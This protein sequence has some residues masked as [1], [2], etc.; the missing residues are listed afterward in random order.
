MVQ[1]SMVVRATEG[2]SAAPERWILVIDDD[3]EFRDALCELL[4]DEGLHVRTAE[5]PA[6]AIRELQ[7]I[8]FD[9]VISDL[10]MPGNGHLVV[11]YLNIH[12]PGTPVIVLSSHEA[13][14]KLLSADDAEAFAFLRKPVQYDDVHDVLVR[15]FELQDHNQR[16]SRFQA[17]GPRFGRG[18]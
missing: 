17:R 8:C 10:I 6:E 13:A 1:L 11:E 15:V 14:W 12:Q 7:S 5:D 4:L 18:H 3:T 16:I 9:A 2:R